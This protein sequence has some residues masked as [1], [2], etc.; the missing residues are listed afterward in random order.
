MG[1]SWKPS[2]VW[3]VSRFWKLRIWR[4]KNNK[5]GCSVFRWNP[6]LDLVSLFSK[7]LFQLTDEIVENQSF[8]FCCSSKK[9]SR[10]FLKNANRSEVLSF[11][12]MSILRLKKP[13]NRL[14]YFFVKRPKVFSFLKSNYLWSWDCSL[15]RQGSGFYSDIAPMVRGSRLSAL[16]LFHL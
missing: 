9:L 12:I 5:I 16:C 6:S 8:F 11:L 3:K 13:K 7:K 14:F 15:F 10:F 4:T 2:R 1:F